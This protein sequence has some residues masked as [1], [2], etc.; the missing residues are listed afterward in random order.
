M[1]ECWRSLT[2]V[3]GAPCGEAG[4]SGRNGNL[5]SA[6]GG[7]EVAGLGVWIEGF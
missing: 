2:A 5:G 4:G 6:H 7:P 3:Q 1:P